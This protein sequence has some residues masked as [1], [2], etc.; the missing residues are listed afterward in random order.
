MAKY[1]VHLTYGIGLNKI[2]Q[3]INSIKQFIITYLI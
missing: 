1:Q 3:I 2:K